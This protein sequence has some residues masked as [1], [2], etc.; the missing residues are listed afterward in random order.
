[1]LGDV[2]LSQRNTQKTNAKSRVKN[3]DYKNNREGERE[4]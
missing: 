4:V 2:E 1:M 3:T